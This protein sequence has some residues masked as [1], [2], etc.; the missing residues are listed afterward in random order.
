V[1]LLDATGGR[2]R[3]L[4]VAKENAV[5]SVAF[6]PKGALA[7]GYARGG[8]AGDFARG[9]AVV[10]DVGGVM[11]LDG[12]PAT[13][14]AKAEQVV[15]RNFTPAEWRQFFP[16]TPYRRTIRSYPWPY[17]LPEAERMRGEAREREHAVRGDAS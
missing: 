17:G 4:A 10:G 2:L 3:D 11:L 8:I 7:A 5:T 15:G 16:N 13:W 14:R 6:G 1:V 12:D 9:V